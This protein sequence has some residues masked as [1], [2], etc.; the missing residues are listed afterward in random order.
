MIIS[1]ALPVLF[2]EC[3]NYVLGGI[4]L[5]VKSKACTSFTNSP[6]IILGLFTG[7]IFKF[8][9]DVF[10]RGQHRIGSALVVI[11]PVYFTLGEANNT[12]LIVI[13]TNGKQMLVSDMRLEKPTLYI[14]ERRVN[15]H[16]NKF[17]SPCSFRRVL[18]LCPRR[19]NPSS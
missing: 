12:G 7:I 18:Q 3:F 4:I 14:V 15:S 8:F 16:D 6:A 9:A 19:H 10:G 5:R 2:A 17:C 11:L 13:V 1:F